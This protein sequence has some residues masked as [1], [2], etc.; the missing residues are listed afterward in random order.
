[1]ILVAWFDHGEERFS[2][3]EVQFKTFCPPVKT[4]CPV[5]ENVNESLVSLG[6]VG[7]FTWQRWCPVRLFAFFL[8]SAS[9]IF[10]EQ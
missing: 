10:D 9:A 7:R 1:V 8:E 3:K 5:A 4:S 6:L 2:C